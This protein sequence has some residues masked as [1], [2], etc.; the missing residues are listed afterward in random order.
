MKRIFLMIA[1]SLTLN[2]CLKEPELTQKEDSGKLPENTVIQPGNDIASGV[3]MLE[4]KLPLRY[5]FSGDGHRL[6]AGAGLRLAFYDIDHIRRVDLNFAQSNWWSLLMNNRSSKTDIPA[7]MSY[8]GTE[9][10]S[11]VGVRFKG[12]TSYDRNNSEKKS[13]AISID[14]EDDKQKVD[15]YND[16]NFNCAYSDNSFMREV[17]YGAVNQ[18]YITALSV[19][20]ID[21]YINGTYWGIYINSQQVDND[22]IEEWYLSKKGSRWRAESPASS[23]G[24]TGGGVRPGGGMPGGG[25]PGGGGQGGGGGMGAGTSSLNYLGD[26]GS[27]YEQYYTLKKTYRNDPWQ[28]LA[29]VCKVLNQTSTSEL[30]AKVCEVLDLDRTLWFLACEI[31]FADDD[32][33]VNK[34]GMDYYIFWCPATGRLTPIEYDGNEVLLSSHTSWSPFYNATNTNYPLLNK[35]LNVPNIR[36]RY[37]AHFRTIL[38]ESFNPDAMNEM[39]DQNAAR[40]DDYIRNDPKKMMTYAQFTNEVSNLKNIINTRYNYLMSNSEV[41]IKGLTINDVQWSVN[42]VAWAQPSKDDRVYVTAKIDGS[43]GV[44]TVFLYG[45]TGL[46]GNFSPVEMVSAGNGVY[47]CYIPAQNQGVRVRF[48]IEA[49]AANSAK[50]KTYNPARAE[51][52][53]YTYVVQ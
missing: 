2:G 5:G 43:I 9:L 48:Y 30:E 11:N 51:H 15:G 6:I 7:R 49:T 16:L 35:L 33:Y 47:G 31:I 25:M 37:L 32:S 12:F 13:F 39:I 52:D 17:I 40:I 44:E 22:L 46:A 29:N 41:N 23:N 14:Y 8:N 26:K 27:S 45:S 36:Q 21:L 19:N 50:T 4:G 20:Y 3:D 42:G 28:D 24:M 53:V 18:R 1:V 38:E 10:P 34:G